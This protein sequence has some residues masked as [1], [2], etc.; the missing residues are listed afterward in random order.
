L[1]FLGFI[2]LIEKK[3]TDSI[4]SIKKWCLAQFDVKQ[5]Q[6]YLHIGEVI[7][8]HSEHTKKNGEVV[9]GVMDP[10]LIA[11]RTEVAPW[12]SEELKR[13]LIKCLDDGL[14]ASQVFKEHKN[15]CYEGW[16]KNRKHSK[17]NPLLLEHV[18]YYE[19]QKKKKWYKHKNALVY[20]NMWKL[21]N[22]NVVFYYQNDNATRVMFLPLVFKFYSKKNSFK[23]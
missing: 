17:D 10:D 21:E 1:F 11:R 19:Y 13:W 7:Y 20:A 8:Y 6:S 12:K 16:I 4:L 18:R 22:A 2:V 9:H 3:I 14:T 5:L 15:V 23:I